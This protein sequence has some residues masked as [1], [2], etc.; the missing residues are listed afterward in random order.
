MNNHRNQNT[1]PKT[2]NDSSSET[3]GEPRGGSAGAAPRRFSA[4]PLLGHFRL[5]RFTPHLLLALV[6]RALLCL[7]Q[8]PALLL[9]HYHW[10][11]L[12]LVIL[13]LQ[14]RYLLLVFTFHR[15]E[16]LFQLKILSLKTEN[17][18]LRRYREFIWHVSAF[19]ARM[20]GC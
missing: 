20:F 18:A 3:G 8:L 4:A 19:R 14:F 2:P 7:H 10:L 1:R 12:Q 11:S 9:A 13:R 15:Y 5:S 17:F 16:L 6:D